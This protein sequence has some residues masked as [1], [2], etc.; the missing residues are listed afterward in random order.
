MSRLSCHLA[1]NEILEKILKFF[2]IWPG[3]K[4]GC[5]Y[6]VEEEVVVS[7]WSCVESAT[8][9]FFLPTTGRIY[10]LFIRNTLLIFC[11]VEN[12]IGNFQ[13]CGSCVFMSDK[14]FHKI[15]T[16]FLAQ[17]KKAIL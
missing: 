17:G 3:K 12:D 11:S 8:L 13:I 2:A 16:I 10:L 7:N 14:I 1:K 4:M 5:P 15:C 9:N 6:F